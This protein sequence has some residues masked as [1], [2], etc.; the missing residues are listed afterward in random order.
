MKQYTATLYC[1]SNSKGP[2]YLISVFPKKHADY[3]AN[4]FVDFHT[5]DALDIHKLREMHSFTRGFRGPIG[6][7]L[8]GLEGIIGRK[9]L[10]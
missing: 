2:C 1:G 4:G 8:Q 9:L 6:E 10:N 3:L 5:I 7:Y